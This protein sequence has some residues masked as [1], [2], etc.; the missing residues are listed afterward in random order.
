MATIL[1]VDSDPEEAQKLCALLEQAGHQV[2][3]ERSAER[4]LLFIQQGARFDALVL[5]LFLH[6]MDGTELCRSMQ[7]DSHLQ[8]M[9]KVAFTTPGHRLKLDWGSE[10]P[11]WMPIDHF[12][13]E[14]QDP[15]LVVQA[16]EQLL[17]R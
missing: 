9:P 12:I 17:T 13:G 10:L 1:Y 2:R 11:H 4:A 8:Q 3:V 5:N 14:L 15:A 16:L 7:K 6:G